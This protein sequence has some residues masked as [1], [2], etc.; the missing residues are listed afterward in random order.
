[1]PGRWRDDFNVGRRRVQDAFDG[2]RPSL[3]ARV[4]R[5]QLPVVARAERDEPFIN[6]QL[7]DSA[8]ERQHGDAAAMA[9]NER[10]RAL[11]GEVS[12]LA[13]TAVARVAAL[14]TQLT[15]TQGHA[16]RMME[17]LELPGARQMLRRMCHPDSNPQAEEAERRARTEATSKINAVY[18]WIE[19]NKAV[20]E[21]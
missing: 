1:M 20:R 14:E 16:A 4:A 12:E 19:R 6:A 11:L 15:E 7:Y 9:E 21:Q 5:P 10:L 8:G 18:E 13:E 2:R 17:V 3:G